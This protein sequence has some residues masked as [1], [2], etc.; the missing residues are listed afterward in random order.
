MSEEPAAARPSAPAPLEDEEIAHLVR[1]PIDADG[2][3]AV[4]LGTIAWAVTTVVL[5]LMRSQLESRGQQ[6]WIA[7]ALTGTALGL[8]GLPYVLRR[9]ATYR[10]HAARARVEQSDA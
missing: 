8:I 10:A 4:V 6:W 7:V 1:T 2:V 9:R 3:S 5:L